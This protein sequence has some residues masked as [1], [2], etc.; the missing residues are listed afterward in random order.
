MHS[1]FI[2]EIEKGIKAKSTKSDGF[3]G[4]FNQNF[5]DQLGQILYKLSQIDLTFWVSTLSKRREELQ[6]PG[7]GEPVGH[8]LLHSCCRIGHWT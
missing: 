5:K 3:T 4:E 2:E 1:I 6:F 8:S 7:A